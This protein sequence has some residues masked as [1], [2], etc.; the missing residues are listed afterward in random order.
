MRIQ[1]LRE[2]QKQQQKG[3][4]PAPPRLETMQS[5][6]PPPA[7]LFKPPKDEENITGTKRKAVEKGKK[8]EKKAKKKEKSSKK[9]KK[10]D[11]KDKKKKKEKKSKKKKKK[12]DSSSSD[13]SSDSSS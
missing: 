8:S 1:R 4:A 12:S 13:S 6:L 3:T 2:E 9:D 7:N 11:K 5:F 10:K